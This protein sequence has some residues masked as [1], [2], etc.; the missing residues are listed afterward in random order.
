M[1]MDK[2]EISILDTNLLVEFPQSKDDRGKLTVISKQNSFTEDPKSI[3][4]IHDIPETQTRGNHAHKTLQQIIFA[5]S[6]SFEVK[7]FDGKKRK[8]YLLNTPSI[9]LI[10]P[11][12]IWVDIDKFSKDAVILVLADKEYDEDEYIRNFN[13]YMDLID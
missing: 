10:I 7:L 5:V 8:T 4:F 9:G 11:K 6:G 3:Y 12:M 1:I 13:N 2:L